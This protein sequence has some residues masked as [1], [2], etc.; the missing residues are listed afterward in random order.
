MYI[1]ET[2]VVLICQHLAT[3]GSRAQYRTLL[4]FQSSQVIR[5]DCSLAPVRISIDNE[6]ILNNLHGS[7]S[8]LIFQ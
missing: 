2:I 8:G 3:N 6:F 4:I 1:S 7:Y 5:I